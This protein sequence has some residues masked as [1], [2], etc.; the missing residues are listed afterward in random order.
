MPFQSFQPSTLLNPIPNAG[1]ARTQPTSITLIPVNRHPRLTHLAMS[2]RDC[3]PPASMSALVRN[4]Q[5]L[6]QLPCSPRNPQQR[7]RPQVP[8]RKLLR[9]PIEHRVVPVVASTRFPLSAAAVAE[10][11]S[12]FA[13][14]VSF[15]RGGVG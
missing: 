8:D 11:G 9:P 2:I 4:T 12:T 5:L 3:L 13:V 6:S 1:R 10:L 7:R 14:T 15:A